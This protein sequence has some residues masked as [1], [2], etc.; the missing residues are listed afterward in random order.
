MD[1]GKSTQTL[2]TTPVQVF[3]YETGKY[4]TEYKIPNLSV[5]NMSFVESRKAL[6]MLSTSQHKLFI[7]NT[8]QENVV[9]QISTTF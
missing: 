5:D 3:N 4:V 6:V 9:L 7:I 1:G 2:P 8:S